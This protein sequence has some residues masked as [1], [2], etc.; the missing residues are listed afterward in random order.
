MCS[1]EFWTAPGLLEPTLSL[2]LDGEWDGT[3]N[4]VSNCFV[5]LM[6]VCVCLCVC[7]IVCLTCD[8][9]CSVYCHVLRARQRHVGALTQLAVSWRASCW[10]TMKWTE[11]ERGETSNTWKNRNPN[12]ESTSVRDEAFTRYSTIGN[13]EE[14]RGEENCKA[15]REA[16]RHRSARQRATCIEI[17]SRVNVQCTSEWRERERDNSKTDDND[18]CYWWRRWAHHRHRHYATR[19]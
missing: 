1:L 11:Q 12:A 6:C 4:S 14:T 7:P 5:C 18:H 3:S 17:E 8:L 2:R 13:E 19:L 10:T 15:W 9:H 16:T